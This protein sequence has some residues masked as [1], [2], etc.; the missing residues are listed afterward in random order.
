MTLE[1]S[2]TP[3]AN[4]KL[5]YLSTLL[6]CEELHKF[7]TLCLQIGGTTVTHLNQVILGLGTYFHPV[8]ALSK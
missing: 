1:T 3:V 6:R 2:G 5:H 7:E 8:N 4:T